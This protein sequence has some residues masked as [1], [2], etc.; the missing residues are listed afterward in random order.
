MRRAFLLIFLITLLAYGC[1]GYRSTETIRP[2]QVQRQMPEITMAHSYYSRND[3]LFLLLKF[4]DAQQVLD[5]LQA[6]TSYEYAVRAGL[7]D[8]DAVILQDSVDLP[9]R[10]IT[11]VEGQ[12][13]VQLALP[14]S[15]VRKP[16]VLHI[17]V[18]E[19]LS[20]RERVGIQFKIA[21]NSEMLQKNYSL[22][23]AN[24]GHSVLKTYL[25]TNDKLMVQTH[26]DSGST[27]TLE[28]F[29]LD[30]MPASPPMS[31]RKPSVPRTLSPISTRSLTASDTL[32]FDNEGLYLLKTE[33]GFANGLLVLAGNYPQVTRAEELIPPLIYLTTSQEREELMQA[34]EPKAAVDNFWLSVGG[35]ERQGRAL[36]KEFYSRVERANKLYTAHKAGWATD[37][38]MVYI[39]YGQPSS[40]SQV[41]P[42]ITWIYRESE[43]A[44][45]IK[46]VF[47]K[48]ENNFTE[49]YYELIRRREYE[50]S[51]YSTVAKWRAGKINL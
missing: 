17:K 12:L 31:M 1:G 47:T 27:L 43:T 21:L 33:K 39:I 36:I 10:K 37:R 38:G 7:S 11:D 3:S 16:N 8:R 26:G 24:T 23:H 49:N 32:I 44:P 45:Y 42:N 22:V 18:W 4:E 46:F 34:K 50:D 15:V 20:G 6:A 14:A 13:Q 41:G 25:T 19:L 2:V 48:K 5:I 51:W 30:F 29:E 40:I 28:R 35:S 9:N